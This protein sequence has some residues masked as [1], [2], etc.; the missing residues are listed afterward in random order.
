MA[1]KWFFALNEEGN[2]FANYSDL[3]KVAV[4]TAL[5]KT[6]LDP[7]FI[8]DGK[9]ND[10]TAWLRKR[11]VKI[12]NKRSFLFE[13]LKAESERRNNPLFLHIGAGA[14]LRL[15]IPQ[16]VKELNYSDKFVL[17]TDVD[18]MF[19][20]EVC[21]YLEALKPKY[22]AVAPEEIKHDYNYVNTG[23][24]LMNVENLTGNEKAFRD[25]V[26]KNLSRL[27]DFAFDQGAYNLFYR[28]GRISRRI[29]GNKWN[30]LNPLYNWKPYWGK[31]KEAKVIHFHGPKPY[32]AE[33]LLSDSVPENIKC[34]AP[35]VRGG[36]LEYVDEWKSNFGLAN[37]MN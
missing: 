18:V 14:F 7:H 6:N 10:L 31:S 30:K 12:I 29:L 36:Y 19:N 21:D 33:A 37:E 26:V 32:Q 11:D 2:Q 9:E 3:V 17:Y 15:E 35:L 13:K 20:G 25:Y 28:R 1:M 23:V 22:F 5:Q 4:F 27:V 24:M 16:I 8:Y 34:I